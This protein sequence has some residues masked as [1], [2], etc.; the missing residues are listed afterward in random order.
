MRSYPSLVVAGLAVC[1]AV[2][3]RGVEVADGGLVLRLSAP[4]C[5][6]GGQDVRVL[7]RELAHELAEAA[8]A[9]RRSG[10]VVL[11]STR[12]IVFSGHAYKRQDGE[13][14]E[15]WFCLPEG[16][17]PGRASLDAWAG[18]APGARVIF[19]I[20]DACSS[21]WIDVESP[22]R[23][24]SVLAASPVPVA[25][26]GGFARAVAHALGFDR[27]IDLNGDNLVTDA[28]I[29]LDVRRHLKRRFGYVR[30]RPAPVWRRNSR[31]DVPV[32][33]FPGEIA[34]EAMAAAVTAAAA[35]P[36]ALGR[37][38]ARQR[39]LG[40][41]GR[42]DYPEPLPPFFVVETDAAR[43]DAVASAARAA[44][45][46]PLPAGLEARAAL[47]ARFM[48]FADVSRSGGTAVGSRSGG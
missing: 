47:I 40:R 42:G 37:E 36:G 12:L 6:G 21:G 29:H 44:K 30:A 39:E 8:R 10:A 16:D 28:E 25:G 46:S 5:A 23:V 3:A 13:R 17:R 41:T 11:P 2:K 32:A 18:E 45:L 14:E 34:D 35:S 7:Q 22:S 43:R 33:A 38:I 1:V 27:S 26:E 19:A 9:R 15:T 48:I 4:T 20:V 31:A 24:I